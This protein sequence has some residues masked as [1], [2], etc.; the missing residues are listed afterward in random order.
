MIKSIAMKN[1][2]SHKDTTVI[3]CDGI[4][5]IV[6]L[7]DSGK[8]S[9]LRAIDWVVNN[10]PSGEEFISSWSDETSVAITLDNGVVVKRGRTPS[11]NYYMINDEIFRAFGVHVPVE[12]KNVMNME[13]INIEKQLDPPFL[14]GSSPGEVAQILNQIVDL[15]GIDHAISNIRKE[16]MKADQEHKTEKTRWEESIEQLRQ[17]DNLPAMEKDVDCI[18]VTAQHIEDAHRKIKNINK[19]IRNMEYQQDLISEHASD[20]LFENQINNCQT[21]YDKLKTE[22][23]KK[24]TIN[25]LLETHKSKM[26]KIT[27]YNLMIKNNAIIDKC[28]DLVNKIIYKNQHMKSINALVDSHESTKK[29][30]EQQSQIIEN[31][32]LIHK[33]LKSVDD[34]KIH[35]NKMK[36]INVL[37]DNIE[38]E[39]KKQLTQELIIEKLE[40]KYATLFPDVCPL[41]GVSQ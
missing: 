28:F 3:F 32:Q 35:S 15:G 41:C 27:K 21:Q 17:Y 33:S 34:I 13:Q 8:T 24:T 6:G 19:L 18:Q 38:V 26:H 29:E 20:L 5:A 7:S 25:N 10:K 9:I 4:N 14:L 39:Q 22:F 16:K 12:I 31:E 11:D 23:R 36:S 37:L 1:F 2:Q 40:K 30:I